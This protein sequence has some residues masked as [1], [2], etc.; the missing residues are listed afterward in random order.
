[1]LQVGHGDFVVDWPTRF[2]ATTSITD[3]WGSAAEGSSSVALPPTAV[4]AS[5]VVTQHPTLGRSAV[6]SYSNGANTPDEDEWGVG[7][8]A[9]TLSGSS[10]AQGTSAHTN[11]QRH[12]IL[13]DLSHYCRDLAVVV[14]GQQQINFV[15][16]RRPSAGKHLT[17]TT[18]SAES[19]PLGLATVV[20]G[21]DGRAAYACDGRNIS[22][23]VVADSADAEMLAN[24]ELN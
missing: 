4:T 9:D 3:D 8:V 20:L 1:M 24:A 23:S 18:G 14:M 22:S 7:V 15:Q 2:T 17:S 19:G 5:A 13:Q 21:L 6:G 11:P 12:L 10:G 16:R